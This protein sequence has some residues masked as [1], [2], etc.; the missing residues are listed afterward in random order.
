MSL[1]F[2][3]LA[4]S[5]SNISVGNNTPIES[6]DIYDIGLKIQASSYPLFDS[7][8]F[9]RPYKTSEFSK[10]VCDKDYFFIWSRDHGSSSGAYLF[11]G[12]GNNLDLSDFTYI[13]KLN[14]EGS[15]I[16]TPYLVERNGVLFM[17]CHTN[18]GGENGNAQQTKLFTYSGVANELNLIDSWVDEGR[19]LGIVGDDN[20][21]GYFN[22]YPNSG[23]GDIGIHITK[24]GLPQPCASSISSDGGYTYTRLEEDIDSSTGTEPNYFAQLQ[25]GRYFTYKGQQFWLGHLHPKLGY[26]GA[27]IH[28]MEKKIII[29]KATNTSFS[30]VTQK[31][32]IYPELMLRSMPYIDGDMA[33][34]YFTRLKGDLYYGKYDL[35]NLDQWLT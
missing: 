25:D 4:A 17:Y 6:A 19:P 10:V 33:H 18:K 21:T 35:R 27:D 7:L 31:R 23:L 29:A 30:S 24:G 2:N 8:Y 13:D 15:Q 11:L 14:I 1:F 34:I 28:A 3:I 16:E 20:H 9:F 32:Q 12:K 5:T 22:P 26:Q